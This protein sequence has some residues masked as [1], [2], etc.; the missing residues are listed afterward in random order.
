[1]SRLL[2]ALACLATVAS[3]A[4]AKPLHETSSCPEGQFY[5]AFISKCISSDLK[6]PDA[7][8]SSSKSNQKATKPY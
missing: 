6:C 1:M 7:K 3:S 2:V 4:L 5:C 8:A